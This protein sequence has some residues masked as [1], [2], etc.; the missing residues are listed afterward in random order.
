VWTATGGTA[1]PVTASADL[2]EAVRSVLADPAYG[3]VVAFR[4]G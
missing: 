3:R 2:P 1:A 4:Q